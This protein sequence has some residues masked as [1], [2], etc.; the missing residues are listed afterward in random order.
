[1]A[2]TSQAANKS[3]ISAPEQQPAA[4]N[5]KFEPLF[6]F[7]IPEAEIRKQQEEEAKANT[8]GGTSIKR[9]KTIAKFEPTGFGLLYSAGVIESISGKN[10]APK[11]FRIPTR[12]EVL[13]DIYFNSFKSKNQNFWFNPN[14][15]AES[16]NYLNL[17]GIGRIN[18]LDGSI[19]GLKAYLYILSKAEDPLIIKGFS[20]DFNGNLSAS[21]SPNIKEAYAIYCI[22]EN[23]KDWYEGMTVK[24]IDGNIYGTTKINNN[25]WLTS[26]LAVTKF[27]DNT[28]ITLKNTSTE[29]LEAV[30]NESGIIPCYSYP[31]RN[32]QNVGK[33]SQLY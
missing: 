18:Y 31:M 26:N 24:D 17:V 8:S 28:P 1:L 20:Y 2:K 3:N 22:M 9:A 19:Y 6:D 7:V 12:E 15:G 30:N 27:N 33:T 13:K 25:V 29:W 4:P 5:S 16:K 11:G 23:P 21:N 32:S 10:I 14:T